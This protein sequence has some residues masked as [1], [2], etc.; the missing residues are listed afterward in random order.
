MRQARTGMAG[1]AQYCSLGNYLG[2]GEMISKRKCVLPLLM[3][4]VVYGL[5]LPGDIAKRHQ[6]PGCMTRAALVAPD[7]SGPK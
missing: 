2:Y 5:V 3:C 1:L 6:V 7:T 4:Y